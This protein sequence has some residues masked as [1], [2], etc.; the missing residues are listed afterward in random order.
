MLGAGL[1]VLGRNEPLVVGHRDIGPARQA[2]L[3]HPGAV[4]QHHQREHGLAGLAVEQ[5]GQHGHQ[6][7]QVHA[8]QPGRLGHDPGLGEVDE[9]QR[10][11][12]VGIDQAQLMGLAKRNHQQAEQLTHV[13]QRK[14][15][16]RRPHQQLV[17]LR[18]RHGTN[19]QIGQ[20]WFQVARNGRLGSGLALGRQRAVAAHAVAVPVEQL[21]NGGQA[22]QGN[23][24]IWIT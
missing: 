17:Q 14:Y 23:G 22:A 16:L 24:G 18:C 20:P 6:F 2:G 19:R 8:T 7:D 3:A 9:L 1:G 12:R 13:G 5:A 10:G 4:T 11:H 21:A 15:F